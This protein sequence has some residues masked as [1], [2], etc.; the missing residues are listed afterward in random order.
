MDDVL[1]LKRRVLELENS[2]GKERTRSHELELRLLEGGGGGG[3]EEPFRPKIETMSSEVTDSNPYSRLMALKRMGIVDNYE[4]IRTFAVAVVGVGGVGSVT[5]EMLTRCGIGK[6]LLFDY[7]RVEL[8]NMNRLFF[9]PHQAGLSKVSAAEFTLRNINPDVQFETHNYNITSLQH[10]QHFL[11]RISGGGL[12]GS[13]VDLVLS[14]VDNFEARMAINTACNELGQMW[15]ESGVSENAVSGHI[16]I[17]IPGRTACFACAPP[18]VVAEGLD[19]STLKRD[20]VCAASLPTTMAVVAGLLVQNA[21]KHL[22]G[23]GT[24]SSYLGY[25]ALQDFFPNMSVRPNPSCDELYCRKRQ[26]EELARRA[27]QLESVEPALKET[28]DVVLHEENTWGI[29]LVGETTTEEEAAAT[30]QVPHLPEGLS[31]AYTR[32][33]QVSLGEE[34][35]DTEES[36]DSLMAQLKCL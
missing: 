36:L 19:E 7:D 27:A 12:S 30:G 9:Q 15:M 28:S 4:K 25:N 5:A 32:P 6:L 10:F 35:E 11:S 21:L 13:S 1:Q 23:F 18:L 24:V 17:I 29:E 22:L 14:C 20:G 16:Q 2:L 8:A 3:G 34:V 31:L 33:A 26:G